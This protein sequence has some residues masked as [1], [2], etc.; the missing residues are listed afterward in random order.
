MPFTDERLG[1]LQVL[2]T[3]LSSDSMTRSSV[4]T[5]DFL[6]HTCA[7]VLFFFNTSSLGDLVGL[8]FL[9]EHSHFPPQYG[10]LS[11]TTP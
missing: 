4:Y 8:L 2:I 6:F 5:S 9:L 11:D 7:Y 3:T 10:I 1:I